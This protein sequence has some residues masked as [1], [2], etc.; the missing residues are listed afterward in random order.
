MCVLCLCW[1]ASDTMRVL[2]LYRRAHCAVGHNYQYT[3]AAQRT[4][5]VTDQTLFHRSGWIVDYIIRSRSLGLATQY[6]FVTRRNRKIIV[7]DRKGWRQRGRGARRVIAGVHY[8]ISIGVLFFPLK[9]R[10]RNFILRSWVLV[11]ISVTEKN[12]V[13]RERAL[14]GRKRDRYPLS[15]F[16][17]FPPPPVSLLGWRRSGLE[18]WGKKGRMKAEWRGWGWSRRPPTFPE[19]TRAQVLSFSNPG[20]ASS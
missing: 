4:L 17:P 19:W 18:E 20:A 1:T 7:T 6:L 11:P 10:D 13:E 12:G 3:S 8:R 16:S 2:Q 5:V 14:R 9:W 15:T